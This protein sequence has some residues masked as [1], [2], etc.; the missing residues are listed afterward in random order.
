MYN[1]FE[2]S[3]FDIERFLKEK[4]LTV[5][6]VSEWTEY[7]S[8]KHLG[9]L[10]NV[11]ITK[12]NTTYYSKDGKTVSNL[13]EKFKVKVTKDVTPSVGAVI[14]LINPTGNAYGKKLPD[15]SWSKFKDQLSVTCDDIT[16][17]TP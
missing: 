8:K 16:V 1:L 15:G 7:G 2:F 11:C 13:M 4:E 6:G 3:K 9:T 17:V 14:E 12:D 5:T 10:L